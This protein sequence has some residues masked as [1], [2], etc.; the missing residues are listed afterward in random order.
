M[1]IHYITIVPDKKRV[2]LNNCLSGVLD[3]YLPYLCKEMSALLSV[4]WSVQDNCQKII[5]ASICVPLRLI[6]FKMECSDKNA[7]T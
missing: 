3:E 2:S 6:M 5:F 4:T 1:N 7:R